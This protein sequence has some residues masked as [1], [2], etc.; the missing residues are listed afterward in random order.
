MTLNT[1][2]PWKSN[3]LLPVIHTFDEQQVLENTEFA[4]QNGADGVVLNNHPS[5]YLRQMYRKTMNTTDELIQIFS[6]AIKN[7]FPGTFVWIND[8]SRD[9]EDLFSHLKNTTSV[10]AI[11]TD[12]SHIT[13]MHQGN[14]EDI[15]LASQ[16]DANR[17]GL[18][19]GSVNFK[20]QNNHLS[21]DELRSM[22]DLFDQYLD[23]IVTSGSGTW[24]AADIQK[25][26]KFS[27]IFGSDKLALAS[28]VTPENYR[29]YQDY[30]KYFLVST[31][32]QKDNG[33]PISNFHYFSKQKIADLAGQIKSYEINSLASPLFWS[34]AST[35]LLNILNTPDVINITSWS[36][37]PL[38][39]MLSNLSP[40]PFIFKDQ[41]FASVEWFWMS[42][43]FPPN[44][45]RKEE[46]KH[47]S[48]LAAK[49]FW[50]PVKDTP[51]VYWW[52]SVIQSWSAEH[53]ELLKD[54]IWAKLQQNPE[55][56]I[57]LSKSWKKP[58]V[59]LP[60]HGENVLY[61]DSTTIPAKKFAQILTDLRK[62]IQGEISDLW[63]MNLLNF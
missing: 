8:L 45:P 16:Y 42:L 28:G 35:E 50:N 48:W 43:K 57:L 38:A 5:N 4:L 30:V 32:L 52:D 39:H 17:K 7:A 1:F 12:Q 60:L 26:Q 61:P 6:P 24:Y 47:M 10:D 63:L 53:H 9:P 18:Y 33:D 55:I 56:Y 59:H 20:Y 40:S 23:V 31:G 13:G 3:V 29:N 19:M 15:I 62:K 11:W 14:K 37:D 36:K 54:A 2:F 46:A 44:D 21:Y 49:K 41:Q 34:T 58:I 27:E 25:I 51:V 22:K